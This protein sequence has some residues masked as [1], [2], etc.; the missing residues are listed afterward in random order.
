MALDSCIAI[1]YHQIV[2]FQLQSSRSFEPSNYRS[3]IVEARTDSCGNRG[4]SVFAF[5]WQNSLRASF[6]VVEQT[7]SVHHV[8]CVGELRLISFDPIFSGHDSHL[9]LQIGPSQ[10]YSE[11]ATLFKAGNRCMI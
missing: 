10:T 8:C 2:Q 4:N 6:D 5:I 1:I 9:K 7:I 11:N 3:G